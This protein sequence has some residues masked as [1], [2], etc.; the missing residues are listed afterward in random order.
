[1]M[2]FPIKI[3]SV[4]AKKVLETCTCGSVHSV[5]RK[6]ANLQFG[7]HLLSLQTSGSP[8]SPLSLITELDQTGMASLK[9][10]AGQPVT[11]KT[12]CL[13]LTAPPFCSFPYIDAHTVDLALKVPV[14]PVQTSLIAEALA[15]SSGCGFGNLFPSDRHPFFT[16][17]VPGNQELILSAARL[18]IDGCTRYFN[19]GAYEQAA[20]ELS[21]LL[22]LGIGLTPSG[23][24]F[25]CGVLAG[26]TLGGNPRHPFSH[27]LQNILTGRLSDTND[28]S[29]A[30]LACALQSQ[31]SH[32]VISLPQ[33]AS[34]KELLAGFEAIGHSSGVDTLCGIYYAISLFS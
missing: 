24:D 22:G 26:L 21:L 32:A 18:R 4:Y 16:G 27:A 2:Q 10:E 12:D 20:Q 13:Y 8:L 31:Y 23:D 29:R 17:S 11:A 25:L 30:F 9:L 3:M 1:M 28:I 6:T 5:Y 14:K 15:R 34:P 19:K 7:N 33:A